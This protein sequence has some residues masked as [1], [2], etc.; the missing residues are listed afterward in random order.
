MFSDN[1]SIDPSDLVWQQARLIMSR[2][3]LGLRSSSQHSSAA[4]LA[5]FSMS[6]FA[7][8]TKHHLFHPLGHFNTCVSP[9]EVVSFNE[10]LDSPMNQKKLSSR[11][12]N[13][14]FQLL[15]DASAIP[16]RAQLM[17]VSSNLAASWLSVVPSP[18]FNLHLD[19]DECQTSIKQWL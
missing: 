13:K 11:I 19:N 5:S 1:M 12:E 3:D 14:Q 15:Y 18:G 10:L 7:S 6:G 2:G 8:N 4:L 9:A 16:N 17:S